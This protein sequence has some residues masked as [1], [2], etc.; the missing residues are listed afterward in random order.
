MVPP[1]GLEFTINQP[2]DYGLHAARLISNPHGARTTMNESISRHSEGAKRLRNLKQDP[3][4]KAFR[5]TTKQ[6][7]S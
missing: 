5:M 6:R 7:L 2:E 4:G 1:D 3:S